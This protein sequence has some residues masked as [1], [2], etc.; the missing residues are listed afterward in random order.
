MI[1]PERE[2]NNH[3]YDIELKE[4]FRKEIVFFM[5]MVTDIRVKDLTKTPG[6]KGADKEEMKDKKEENKQ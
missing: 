6:T 2:Y 1:H 5:K 3:R 4:R